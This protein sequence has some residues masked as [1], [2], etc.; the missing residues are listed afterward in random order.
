MP[1]VFRGVVLVIVGQEVSRWFLPWRY[2]AAVVLTVCLLGTPARAQTIL[3]VD[4]SVGEPAG[5]GSTW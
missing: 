3:Y 5:D 1:A 2:V 4:I